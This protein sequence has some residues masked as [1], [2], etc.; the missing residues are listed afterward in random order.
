MFYRHSN[1]TCQS[2]DKVL[3]IVN[4]NKLSDVFCAIIDM[5][6]FSFDGKYYTYKNIKFSI[7]I[8]ATYLYI[9]PINLERKY[10]SDP[11][12]PNGQL[13]ISINDTYVA[14]MHNNARIILND[15]DINNKV[16]MEFSRLIDRVTA[17]YNVIFEK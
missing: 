13:V 11:P 9:S 3:P 4:D 2:L 16:Q 7:L 14:F 1:I 12:S 8:S 17:H 15:I 10:N 6:N 5:L